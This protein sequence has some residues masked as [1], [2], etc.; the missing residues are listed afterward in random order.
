[1]LKNF[2]DKFEEVLEN[3]DINTEYTQLFGKIY[4]EIMD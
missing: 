3:V 2:W 4:I 1:M